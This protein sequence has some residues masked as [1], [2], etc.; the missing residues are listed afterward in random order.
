ML[1]ERI[2]DE[3][4]EAHWPTAGTRL[5]LTVHDVWQIFRSSSSE[6]IAM[7][8]AAHSRQGYNPA[9]RVR[10]VFFC[11]AN[12]RFLC[13]TEVRAVFM[14]VLDVITHQPLEMAFIEY[15][16]MVEQI[17]SAAADEALSNPI[18]PRALERCADRFDPDDLYSFHN[19][20]IEDGVAVVDQIF[21]S[22]VVRKGV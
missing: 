3:A 14:E 10:V 2:E 12:R 11:S 6:S 13:Q 8:Q 5:L 21:R 20:G 17:A 15:D 22:R 18:L 1:H 4:T 16:D 19:F 7:M 9:G